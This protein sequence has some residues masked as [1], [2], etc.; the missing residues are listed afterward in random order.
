M[1]GPFTEI[2]CRFDGFLLGGGKVCCELTLDRWAE[3]IVESELLN[4]ECSLSERES[5][6]GVNVLDLFGCSGG[7]GGMNGSKSKIWFI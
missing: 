3:F 1:L 2:F 5:V 7:G 6:A 4:I